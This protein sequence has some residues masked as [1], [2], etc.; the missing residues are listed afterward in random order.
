MANSTHVGTDTGFTIYHHPHLAQSLEG[1]RK[2]REQEYNRDNPFYLP[3]YTEV[4]T[5]R[6]KPRRDIYKQFLRK[7]IIYQGLKAEERWREAVEHSTNWTE[8][9][10]QSLS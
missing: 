7:P 2:L 10:G 5:K 9:G 6:P 8:S 1:D 4:W 3:F